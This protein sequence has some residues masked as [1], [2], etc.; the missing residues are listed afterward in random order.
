[1]ELKEFAKKR[2]QDQ[3]RKNGHQMKRPLSL[4]MKSKMIKAFK[5]SQRRKQVHA[6]PLE[7]QCFMPEQQRQM[8][9]GNKP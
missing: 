4:M 7:E 9:A 3:I 8:R 5:K 1:M 2:R 6:T